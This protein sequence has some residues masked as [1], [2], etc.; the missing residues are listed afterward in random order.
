MWEK[1][2]FIMSQMWDFLR[3][4]IAMFMSEVGPVLASVAMAA[5]EQTAKTM[6]DA[7]GT[8]KKDN[9]YRIMVTMLE[10]K[11]IEIGKQVT[12]RMINTAIE[13]AVAKLKS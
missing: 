7:V 10:M 4:L 12:E 9:A 2:R 11:G 6:V 5:V 8:Q 13:A 1:M 3:P